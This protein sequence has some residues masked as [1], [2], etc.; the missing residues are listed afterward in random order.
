[1]ELVS[2]PIA[3][4]G[5]ELIEVKLA[6]YRK[7]SRLQLF[8][9]SDN[10]VKIDDCVRVSK[11]VRPIFDN[12]GLFKFGYGLEVSSPGLDRPLETTR[13]FRR[14]IGETIEIYFYDKEKP[15]L[16]GELVGV[17]ERYIELQTDQ[18]RSK[19]DLVNVRKGKIIV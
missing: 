11:M 12:S 3:E 15:S 9:D 16:R 1:M 18:G 5:F 6:R 10:G 4:A 8:I 13:D 17:E 7:Q 14:R 19:Y 2:E